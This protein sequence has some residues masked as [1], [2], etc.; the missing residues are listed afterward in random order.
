MQ[1]RLGTPRGQHTA[2][3]RRLSVPAAPAPPIPSCS[4]RITRRIADAGKLA[5]FRAAAANELG[6]GC[7]VIKTIAAADNAVAHAMLRREHVVS[8]DVRH[9]NLNSV[10]AADLSARQ[11]LLILPYLE[12]ISLRRLIASRAAAP[13][14]LPTSYALLVVRQV[15]VALAA[16][17]TAGWLHNQVRPE[18][19]I[20]SPT[21]QAT[22][23]D[24]TLARRLESDE[25]DC[26]EADDNRSATYAAP[27]SFSSRR[28]LTAA[29]D[30]YSLGILL[31]EI[32]A[33][34]PPFAAPSVR[35]LAACH[36]RQA[37]PDLRRMRLGLAYEV[38]QLV[39]CML[40]KEPLRRPSDEQL[41]RW[42]T[43]LEIQALA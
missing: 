22:L 1:A 11:P 30:I 16:M 9:P 20:V 13:H 40:A 14:L 33:G 5:L 15:A 27:E 4:W 12:G 7:Y 3:R 36:Q 19:V 35:Q 10:L 18:H 41:I 28:R 38:A 17:H 2:A 26:G 31:F 34:Q 37:P 21:A 32:L 25:C 43:E 42:L 6:P 24:L 29:S 23:I 39:R 8:S